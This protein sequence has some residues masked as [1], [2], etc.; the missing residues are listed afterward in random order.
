MRGACVQ[1]MCYMESCKLCRLLA[2]TIAW[3]LEY[4][5]SAHVFVQF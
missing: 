1:Q 5:A 3:M 4:I 2:V